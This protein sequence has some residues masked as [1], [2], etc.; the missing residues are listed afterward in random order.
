MK[1]ASIREFRATLAELIEE[2][3]P[4][5][6]TRHGKPA[7]VVYPLEN[8]RIVPL[9]VRQEL[10]DS[11]AHELGFDFQDD[12]IEAYK[13]DVDRTLI[14]ENLRRTPAERLQALV[15]MLRLM[16]EVRSAGSRE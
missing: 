14:R 15:E 4:V 5:V 16:N 13:R 6:I 3:E 1:R 11:A 7:A 9:E 2:K 12:V 10:L 8:M